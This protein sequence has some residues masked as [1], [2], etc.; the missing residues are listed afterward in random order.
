MNR[1]A[2]PV[3]Q[4]RLAAAPELPSVRS[5]ETQ[6]T[7]QDMGIE[8]MFRG[9]VQAKTKQEELAISLGRKHFQEKLQSPTDELFKQAPGWQDYTAT[10]AALSQIQPGDSFQNGIPLEFQG[11]RYTITHVDPEP[12]A[13]GHI[14]LRMGTSSACLFLDEVMADATAEGLKSIETLPP[15]QQTSPDVLLVKATFEGV[16]L[17]PQQ[18]KEAAHRMGFMTTDTVTDLAA[19]MTKD[20]K[21]LLTD[22]DVKTLRG[23]LPPLQDGESPPTL[24]PKAE[25]LQTIL[26]GE[27]VLSAEQVKKVLF[28]LEIPT[29]GKQLGDL[30]RQY[31]TEYKELQAQLDKFTYDGSPEKLAKLK[32][33]QDRL[34][35]LKPN[36]KTYKKIQRELQEQTGSTQFDIVGEFY[37]T[38]QEG[39]GDEVLLQK[40][41]KAATNPTMENIVDFDESLAT[42]KG[43]HDRKTRKEAMQKFLKKFF[44]YGGMGFAGLM[45][46]QIWR[47][48]KKNEDGHG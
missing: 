43:E 27:H 39:R 9:S 20:G 8:Q 46:I 25:E 37:E 34:D 19:G 7:R 48:T 30:T 26:K 44:T 6:N 45:G 3:A 23:E 1:I 36:I 21:P 5:T 29:D 41:T 22:T 15:D 35:W 17:N 40:F 12:D 18:L 28:A 47:A 11:T 13:D 4:A 42:R 31:Q 10:Y 32:Q 38:I 16:T 14:R 24:S 33:M 2:M